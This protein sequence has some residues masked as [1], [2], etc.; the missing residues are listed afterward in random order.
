MR[1]NWS[2]RPNMRYLLIFFTIS[3]KRKSRVFRERD[4]QM[5][6]QEISHGIN[7]GYF[8]RKE[9][10]FFVI[11]ISTLFVYLFVYFL[12]SPFVI[13]FD[14]PPPSECGIL[15]RKYTKSTF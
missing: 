15:V 3:V 1:S 8:V 11:C 7:I 2:I 9:V 14:V 5:L 10:Y 12:F 4:N 13:P 6:S